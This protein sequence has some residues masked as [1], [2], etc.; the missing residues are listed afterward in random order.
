VHQEAYFQAQNI[1]RNGRTVAVV[2]CGGIEVNRAQVERGLAWVY[3]KY[4][5]DLTLIAIEAR[6]QQKRKGLWAG[7]SPTSAMGVSTFQ[8]GTPGRLYPCIK[9]RDAP[10]SLLADRV[11]PLNKNSSIR[12]DNSVKTSTRA[13]QRC[14]VVEQPD[15]DLWS[16]SQKPVG[17]EF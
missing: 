17:T 11:S 7:K 13:V 1:D 9:M 3:G 15:W 8:K 14:P 12:C 2:S 6:A 10:D 5:N 4:N 16:H